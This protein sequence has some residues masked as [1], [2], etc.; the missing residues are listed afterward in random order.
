[1]KDK[2][3]DGVASGESAAGGLKRHLC[4]YYCLLDGATAADGTNTFD[5]MWVIIKMLP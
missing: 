4:L 5:E 3:V 1:M 2:Y